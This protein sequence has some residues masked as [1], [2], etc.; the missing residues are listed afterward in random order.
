LLLARHAGKKQPAEWVAFV[1]EM[2]SR[3]G[4]RLV[5][6]GKT[7]ET[8]EEDIAELTTQANVFAEKQLPILRALGIE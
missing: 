4:Q 5:K 8:A 6:E 1:W 3:Q 7:I 2:I